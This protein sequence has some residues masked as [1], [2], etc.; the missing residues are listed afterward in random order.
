MRAVTKSK[1]QAVGVDDLGAGGGQPP[2]HLGDHA[3]AQQQISPLAAEHGR[4]AD[5]V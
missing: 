5:Q 4:A 3:I 2:A 1:H